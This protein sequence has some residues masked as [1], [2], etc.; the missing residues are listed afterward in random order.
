MRLSFAKLMNSSFEKL[1]QI[2]MEVH[3][4]AQAEPL[5]RLGS[6]RSQRIVNPAW[7]TLRCT[8]SMTRRSHLFSMHC[9]LSSH[10]SSWNPAQSFQL[11]WGRYRRSSCHGAKVIQAKLGKSPLKAPVKDLPTGLSSMSRGLIKCSALLTLVTVF[12]VEKIS[13]GGRPDFCQ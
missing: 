4:G 3:P 12:S 11:T 2:T 1:Q 7:T 8:G 5:P 9:P 10:C 13:G 6:V